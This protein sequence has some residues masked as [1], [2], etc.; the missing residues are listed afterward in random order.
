MVE[1]SLAPFIGRETELEDLN[2]LL[3][4]KTSSLVVIKGRRRIGKSRLIREFVSKYKYIRMVGILPTNET[5]AQSQ[6]D[7]FARQL[8]LGTDLPELKAD[9][10][11]KLFLLL[12]SQVKSGRIMIIFDELSW[13]GSKDSDFLGK[14]QN[15]WDYHFKDNPKLIMILCS[16][17]SVWIEK[18]VL[19]SAGFMGRPSMLVHLNELSI[20]QSNTLIQALGCQFSAYDTF[21]LLSITGGVPRYLEEINPTLSVEENIRRLAFRASGILYREFDDIFTDLFEKRKA[22]YK[23]IVTVLINGALSLDDI[24]NKLNISKGGYISECL[25]ELILSGFVRR[26]Y[27]WILNTGKESSLSLYRLSD[28]YCRFYL[29]YIETN[30]FKIEQGHFNIRS[31]SSLPAWDTIVGLQFENLVLNNRDYIIKSL[32]IDFNDVVADSPF[33]QTKTKRQAGCQIDYLI[34]TRYNVLYVCEIRYSRKPIT[35]KAIQHVQEKIQRILVPRGFTCVP[36]LIHV[37]GVA[38][39]VIDAEYFVNIIDMSDL[40][41]SQTY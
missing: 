38:Q 24:C 25:D 32:H 29:K 12:A 33:F 20:M 36:V 28:N 22:T 7:E 6:R 18:N 14:L 30:K 37:N 16:S 9:D 13:M 3:K 17:A 8:A 34:Q 39:A 15:A 26:D 1:K 41:N 35:T 21:K 10:W 5:T 2:L 11:S 19:S 4:K 40:L 27:T 31:L 23:K